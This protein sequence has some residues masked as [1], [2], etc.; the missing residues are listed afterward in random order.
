MRVRNSWRAGMNRT[1]LTLY[2][3]LILTFLPATGF[4]YAQEAEPE[5]PEIVLPRVILEIEDLSV[6]AISTGIPEDELIP[7]TLEVPLPEPEDLQIVEPSIML[8]LPEAEGS[9]LLREE[10]SYLNFEGVLGVGSRNNF[11]GSFSLYQFERAPEGKLYFGHEVYDGLSGFEEGSGYFLRRDDFEGLVGFDVKKLGID[12]EGSFYDHERG[13]QGLGEY[14]SKISRYGTALGGLQYPIGDRF[15]LGFDLGADVSTQLLTA[16]GSAAPDP[17]KVNEY[18]AYTELSGRYDFER[19][20]VGLVPGF[21]YR[22]G[23]DADA[24][25]LSRARVKGIFGVDLGEVTRLEGD[26]SWF[27][28]DASGSLF[29]FSLG[30]STYPTDLFSLNLSGGYK[31]EQYNL[32]TVFEG[33]PYA[34]TPTE[35]FDNYGWFVDASS[36]IHV[37]R[38]WIINIGLSFM[39]SNAMLSTTATTDPVTGLFPISQNEA[40]QLQAEAGLRWNPSMRF[41]AYVSWIYEILDRPQFYPEHSLNLELN[42]FGNSGKWGVDLTSIQEIGVN[43]FIQAPIVDL[44][45]YYRVAEFIRLAGELNDIVNLAMEDPRYDWYPYVDVGFQVAFKVYINF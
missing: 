8:S 1:C 12:L 18:L 38:S 31:L 14:Y 35:L 27:W 23:G 37:A 21:S 25:N 26:A 39:D 40:T 45:A 11:M 10:G 24:Y 36:H 5:E 7:Q 4:L 28:S 2:I 16:A 17:D 30:I 15:S 34:D 20:F 6:E 13:L 32:N 3:F 43:D 44:S 19:G 41:S 29:P 9:T 22:D 33:Y 42:W